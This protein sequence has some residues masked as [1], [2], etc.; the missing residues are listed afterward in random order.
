MKQEIFDEQFKSDDLF[1]P[2]KRN[3]KIPITSQ[4]KKKKIY[5]LVQEYPRKGSM[6]GSV[7]PTRKFKVKFKKKA[8]KDSSFLNVQ[9][10]VKANKEGSTS[11]REEIIDLFNIFK[12]ANED[13]MIVK[14]KSGISIL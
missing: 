2:K 6:R 3:Q 13:I 5:Y 1:E 12:A 7:T 11:T 9:L 4:G 10:Q 14:Y 8:S